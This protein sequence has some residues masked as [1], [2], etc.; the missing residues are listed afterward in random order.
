M[1]TGTAPAS[2]TSTTAD[3]GD[4]PGTRGLHNVRRMAVG[5]LALVVVIALTSAWWPPVVA[6]DSGEGATLRV[7][8]SAHARPGVDSEVVLTWRLREG[9]EASRST[10]SGQGFGSV[11]R[12]G[13]QRDA[14]DA[15]GITQIYPAPLRQE[16]AGDE[17]VLVY[18]SQAHWEVRLSGRVPTKGT[19]GRDDWRWTAA[20]DDEEQ[21]NVTTTVWSLP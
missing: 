18:R 21:L 16:E 12:I 11:V 13:V 10:G 19:P 2:S 3:L 8:H 9:P 14:L 1:S 15:L 6:T 5:V 4:A 7:S 17:V 20:L